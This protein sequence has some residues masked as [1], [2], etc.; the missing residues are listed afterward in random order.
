[1]LSGDDP[2]SEE[3]QISK[4]NFFK[5]QEKK[6]LGDSNKMKYRHALQIRTDTDGYN[7]GR[8]YYLQ[9][10]SDEQCADLVGQLT[11]QVK[12]ARKKALA[13][14]RFQKSQETVRR[15]YE[16]APCQALVATL[17]VAVSPRRPPAAPSATSHR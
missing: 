16:S 5:E 4:R 8:T 3:D 7:S 15:V 11:K 12:V 10:S 14:T 2:K 9:A 17:I 1:M 6:I 13:R